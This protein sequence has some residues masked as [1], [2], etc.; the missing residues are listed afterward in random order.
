VTVAEGWEQAYY[1]L[2][3]GGSGAGESPLVVSYASSPPVEVEDPATPPDQS[4][5]GVIAE[6]CYRQVEFAGILAGADH[7][8]AAQMV[9]DFLLS[10]PFQNDMPL[11]MYVY[12]VNEDATLPEAFT[13][14]SVQVDEPLLLPSDEVGANRDTWIEQW[15]EIF[16]T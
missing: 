9:I 13:K 11:N 14:Y 3:S 15:T 1:D 16:G 5:T 4:P 8:A 7:E 2:F 12:P 6:S 10:V